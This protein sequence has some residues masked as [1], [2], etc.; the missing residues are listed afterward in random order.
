MLTDE[1]AVTRGEEEVAPGEVTD[2][3]VY[4]TRVKKEKMI[5]RVE[6]EMEVGGD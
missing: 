4:F 5:Q 1:P 2:T 6:K 3:V